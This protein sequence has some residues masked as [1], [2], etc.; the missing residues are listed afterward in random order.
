[1]ISASQRYGVGLR[2]VFHT[3]ET[4]A[5]HAAKPAEYTPQT[6]HHGTHWTL[7]YAPLMPAATG[8]AH[9]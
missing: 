1:M 6:A 7:A 3:A 8:T 4:P 9:A 5:H 2:L